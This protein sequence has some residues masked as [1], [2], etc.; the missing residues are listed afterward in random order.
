MVLAAHRGCFQ[1]HTAAQHWKMKHVHFK[2]YLFWNNMC[3]VSCQWAFGK[4]WIYHPLA[5]QYRRR[6]IAGGWLFLSSPLNVGLQKNRCSF[7]V[8]DSE[9]HWRG[10]LLKAFKHSRTYCTANEQNNKS[11]P[12]CSWLW[13]NEKMYVEYLTIIVMLILNIW[14]FIFQLLSLSISVIIYYQFA[15]S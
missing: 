11:Y 10:I 8:W 4:S 14:A 1:V 6:W 2:R 13:I 9:A 12:I 15:F 5:L 7:C 3:L